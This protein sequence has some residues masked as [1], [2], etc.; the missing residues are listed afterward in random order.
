MGAGALRTGER[1]RGVGERRPRGGGAQSRGEGCS[2]QPGTGAQAGQGEHRPCGPVNKAREGEAASGARAREAGAGGG[3]GAREAPPLT[4]T[5]DAPRIMKIM[6]FALMDIGR[7]RAGPER[8]PPAPAPPR[9]RPDAEPPAPPQ[10]SARR[11][12]TAAGWVRGASRGRGTL[13]EAASGSFGRRATALAALRSALSPASLPSSPRALRP[14]LPARRL[15]EGPH[16]RP[17]PERPPDPSPG[18]RVSVG[19]GALPTTRP[20]WHPG[21]SWG[22]LSLHFFS[23]VSRGSSCWVPGVAVRGSGPTDSSGPAHTTAF[24]GEACRVAG[25]GQGCHSKARDTGPEDSQAKARQ[26]PEGAGPA[27]A[28]MP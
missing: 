16:G 7:G 28:W 23:L 19:P 5:I 10:R 22:S 26:P 24:T 8:R 12:P 20:E 15:R 2:G 13:D 4:I 11:A 3:A 27:S 25:N 1:S 17:A 21:E 6:V 14:P 18:H 9:P